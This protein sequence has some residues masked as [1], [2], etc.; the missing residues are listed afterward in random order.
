MKKFCLALALVLCLASCAC[1][2]T[3]EFMGM[4]FS[5]A[6]KIPRCRGYSGF[7]TFGSVFEICGLREP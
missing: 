4:T 7:G 2:Q 5:K 1:A 3:L 6:D